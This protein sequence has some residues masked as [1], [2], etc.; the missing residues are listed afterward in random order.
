MKDCIFYR[1]SNYGFRAKLAKFFKLNESLH[2]SLLN[3]ILALT[4]TVFIATPAFAAVNLGNA[5]VGSL[6]DSEDSNYLNGSKVTTTNS[7]N[8][9]SM[10]VYVGN[11]DSASNNRK[12]QLAIY[13]N[14]GTT[15]IT[16]VASSATGTLVA[17]SWNTLPINATLQPNTSYWLMYNTNGRTDS[18]NN[19]RYN[20]G[21]SG[22]G[23]YKTASVTFG[24]WPNTFGTSALTSAVYSL[25]ATADSGAVGDT[26]PPTVSITAPG[27]S[28]S[29]SGIV[30]ISA[31]ASDNASI[32]NVQFQIDSSN[33]GGLTTAPPYNFSWNTGLHNNGSHTLTAIARDASGNQTI[34]APITVTIA[35]ADI[36]SQIGEWSPLTSW[37]LVAINANLLKNG[38]VLL[39]DH[40]NAVTGP[41]VWDPVTTEFTSTPLV[42]DE[43]FCSAQVNLA[44]GKV[45][46]AGGHKVGGGQD[47]I[48]S[49][50]IYDADLNTWTKG[51]D[52]A[53]DRWYPG[54]TKLGDGRVVITSGQIVTGSFADTP[55]I[56]DPGTGLLNAIP[57]INTSQLHEEEY[58][59]NFHLPNGKI[60]AI[61][62]EYGPV[63]I[64]GADASTWTNVNTTPVLL[65][66]AVQY[67]PGK[68]LMSGGA[69]AFEGSSPSVTLTAV[70]D[71][72]ASTPTWR[73]TAPMSF[74]RYMHNLVM[75]PTGKVLAVGG[76]AIA[77]QQSN[78]GIL[79]T[80]IWDPA[81]EAWATVASLSAPRV[82][83]STALL[84]PD[85]RVL[86]AGG[87]KNGALSNQYSAQVYSPPYLFK[88]ERPV[89]TSAPDSV[90]YG[91]STFTV[92]SPDAADIASVALI[93]NGSVTH[94]TDMNQFYTELPFTAAN[95]QL[96]VTVP[97]N[98]N[99]V[100]PGHYML[101]IV[102]STGV[103]SAAKIV[104]IGSTSSA[105][106]ITTTSLS[107]GVLGAAYSSTLTS[108]GGVFP[109]TWS[110]TSGL[111]PNGL[112]LNSGTGSIAGTP[113]VA[114]T[115]SFT[116]QVSDSGNGTASRNLSIVVGTGQQAST[117]GLS[118]VG[119]LLDSADSNYLNG[120]KVTTTSGGSIVSMSVYVGNID[121]ASSNR[122]FQLAIYTN[123]GTTPGTL[124]ANSA[125]GTLVANSWNTLPISAALQPNTSYWLM[126]NTNGRTD[127]VNNMYYNNRSNGQGVYSNN[128]VNFGG[129]PASFPAATLTTA[130]YSL[131][132]TFG[133]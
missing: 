26:T 45:F 90:Q 66:S 23:A 19:M 57:S 41:L 33:L 128:S 35:N 105:L 12:F 127:T 27:A 73:T 95:G 56:Y 70:S 49:T 55:E 100:P 34:S 102:D 78:N 3:I 123:S 80:E 72:N 14:N 22:A 77:Y 82:Y 25:Y 21:V 74:G 131:Y 122:S 115:F 97:Q 88:G 103:P 124:V 43:I 98:G 99:Q 28:A 8:I 129:W 75:L 86:A 40:D 79:P 42:N 61:S 106:T 111:L 109:Y 39:F 132:A 130:I 1:N 60:L 47:G 108:S 69:P 110:I 13:T 59:A 31:T 46:I 71:M 93:A 116:V 83:H 114:G 92:D 11:I 62:P 17:N 85:G 126:Y 63:Q 101:F 96:S 81:T 53:Y 112:V 48:K 51:S 67:R 7:A 113:T 30:T 24:T 58:P 44:D 2:G 104:K 64:M 133:P 89:I 125:T 91:T 10:S 18:V 37:P 76:V 6:L 54:L 65:G 119:S 50:Y 87:G 36:R 20:T 52:M 29:V 84:L 38:K 107:G 9:V 16:R 5:S 32:P 94:S 68:I 4:F 118:T 121:S 117:I 120:S 15:P